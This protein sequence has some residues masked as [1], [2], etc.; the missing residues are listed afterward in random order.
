TDHLGLWM[1]FVIAVGRGVANSFNMPARQAMIS[2]LVP[3]DD[4][5]SAVAL[6]A[7]TFNLSKVFGPALG[8]VLIATIG[9]KGAFFLNTVSIA[10]ALYCL[11]IM[12]FPAFE[13]RPG[14]QKSITT[15]LFAGLAYLKRERALR[16]L[17][18][19]ALLPM[20]LGQPYQT[21]LT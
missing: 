4:L 16:T 1:V 12:H 8:G 11:A 10:M 3:K 6:N 7:S 13:R 5:P 14:G 19:L 2:E 17:V 21:M 20:V 15:D 9:V 18:I